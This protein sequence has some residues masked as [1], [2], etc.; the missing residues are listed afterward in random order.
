MKGGRGGVPLTT[1]G[2]G[3]DSTS[4]ATSCDEVPDATA[5]AEGPPPFELVGGTSIACRAGVCRGPSN[6]T[7]T[8]S[9]SDAA[10]AIEATAIVFAQDQCRAGACP[11]IGTTFDAAAVSLDPAG[12]DAARARKAES[13][14]ASTRAGASASFM[15][16]A[17]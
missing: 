6:L 7:S 12:T 17:S 1:S 8:K 14:A 10:A 5:G 11:D 16:A 9:A 4:P 2:V 15:P 13:S 3:A